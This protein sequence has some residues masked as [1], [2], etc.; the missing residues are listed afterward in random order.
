VIYRA[1]PGNMV[2]DNSPKGAPTAD[3]PGLGVFG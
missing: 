2:Y 3:D 1:V